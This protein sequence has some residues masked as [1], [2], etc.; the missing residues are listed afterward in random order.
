MPVYF[1]K[2]VNL[3]RLADTDMTQA[4]FDIVAVVGFSRMKKYLDDG[5]ERVLKRQF[6]TFFSRCPELLAEFKARCILDNPDVEPEFFDKAITIDYLIHSEYSFFHGIIRNEAIDRYVIVDFCAPNFLRT[7][8]AKIRED[9]LPYEYTHSFISL[10]R[11]YFDE[12]EEYI[13]YMEL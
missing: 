9:D 8:I 2:N 10:C 13:S 6:S 7:L 4:A 12:I 3:T 5:A 1:G 11:N